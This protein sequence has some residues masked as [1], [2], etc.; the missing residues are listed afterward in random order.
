MTEGSVLR[1]LVVLFATALPIVF[2]FQRLNIP[3]VVGFLIAG[4]II[5]P[6]GV[7]LIARTSDV[8]NLAE[9][10]LVLLLFVVGLEVSLAQLARLGRVI[11]WSGSLQVLATA[12]LGFGLA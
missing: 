5:G 3:A 2:I 4:I 8:E 10:G 11:I 7:G 12:L 1:D 9:L 6:D